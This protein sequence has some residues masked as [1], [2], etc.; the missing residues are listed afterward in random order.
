[1]V[2]VPEIGNVHGQV[3]SFPAESGMQPDGIKRFDAPV[4]A[5]QDR[6]VADHA[7]QVQGIV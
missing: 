2:A 7:V 1:M 6:V 5:G 4:K 3:H